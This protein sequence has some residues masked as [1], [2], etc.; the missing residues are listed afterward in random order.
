MLAPER[1]TEISPG[2]TRMLCAVGAVG[3][4]SFSGDIFL[5]IVMDRR[6]DEDYSCETAGILRGG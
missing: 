3:Y 4:S 2:P 5:E 1:R 6:Y